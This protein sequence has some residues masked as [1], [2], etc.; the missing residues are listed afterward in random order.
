MQLQFVC[1]LK[2]FALY[3]VVAR[4]SLPRELLVL[5]AAVHDRLAAAAAQQSPA[6]HAAAGEAVA[7]PLVVL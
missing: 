2:E 7:A 1:A 3:A 4:G 6:V 5:F